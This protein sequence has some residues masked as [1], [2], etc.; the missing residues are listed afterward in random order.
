MA[1][2]K[3]KRATPPR[4]AQPRTAARTTVA[5]SEAVDLQP[6]KLDP[7]E[8]IQ[9]VLE[10]ILRH[11]RNEQGAILSGIYNGV[12]NSMLEEIKKADAQSQYLHESA[13]M[14]HKLMDESHH[15][16]PVSNGINKF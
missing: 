16:S 6:G 15:G 5:K 9:Q 1:N 2:A 3:K 13:G 8:T 7:K 4:N 12:R 11:P 14:L 10:V